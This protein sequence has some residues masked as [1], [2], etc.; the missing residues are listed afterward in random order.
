M[1]N[2]DISLEEIKEMTTF[3][4]EENLAWEIESSHNINN[5]YKD[6]HRDNVILLVNELYVRYQEV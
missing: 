4:L 6:I 5:R 3:R 2:V 1:S